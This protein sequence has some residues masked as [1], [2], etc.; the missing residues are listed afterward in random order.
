MVNIIFLK[1]I[2]QFMIHSSTSLEKHQPAEYHGNSTLSIII[3]SLNVLL[4]SVAQWSRSRPSVKMVHVRLSA[5]LFYLCCII[6]FC[7][8]LFLFLI[9]FSPWLVFRYSYCCSITASRGFCTKRISSDVYIILVHSF[10]VQALLIEI[11]STWK[12]QRALK[13]SRKT[14]AHLL[15]FH[16][17]A[18]QIC[19]FPASFWRWGWR[20]LF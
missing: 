17:R 14:I 8:F 7:L 20:S 1:N 18:E 16:K 19:V 15:K 9:T 5:K 4:G 11:W 6:F 13:E 12:V 3:I 10:T 2:F